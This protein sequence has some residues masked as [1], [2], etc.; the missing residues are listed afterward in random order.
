MSNYFEA[1]I[2]ESAKLLKIRYEKLAVPCKLGF[3]TGRPYLIK[4]QKEPYDA[5]LIRDGLH[6]ALEMK[7]SQLFG[8]FPLERLEDHQVEGLQGA[9]A[10]GCPAYLLVNFRKVRDGRKTRELSQS[11]ALPFERWDA[12]N[13]ACGAEGRLSVPKEWFLDP[14]WFIPIPR[15]HVGTELA[16]DLRVILRSRNQERAIAHTTRSGESS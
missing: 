4:L 16:W 11:F 6:H 5:F 1:E 8:S 15:I 14:A 13:E 10:D 3:A 9:M 2:A 12:L 7:S